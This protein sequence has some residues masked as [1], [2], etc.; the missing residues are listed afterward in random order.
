MLDDKRAGFNRA[1]MP[2]RAPADWPPLVLGYRG[3]HT[4]RM[5]LSIPSLKRGWVEKTAELQIT[6][7]DYQA[8]AADGDNA[9]QEISAWLESEEA[10]EFFRQ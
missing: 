6:R 9:S 3:N 8:L 4:F 1:S 5:I 7:T 2:K 10:K